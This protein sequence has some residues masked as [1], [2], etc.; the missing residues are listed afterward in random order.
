MNQQPY[1]VLSVLVEVQRGH[2]GDRGGDSSESGW[3][4][5]GGGTE[6]DRRLDV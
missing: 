5:V 3:E 2:R 6:G 1:S 4:R